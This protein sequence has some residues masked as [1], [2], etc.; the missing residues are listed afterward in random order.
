MDYREQERTLELERLER[1]RVRTNES[2][3]DRD[4]YSKQSVYRQNKMSQYDN[5]RFRR[6]QQHKKQAA[7]SEKKQNE[8]RREKQNE[9]AAEKKLKKQ[10]T[11]WWW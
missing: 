11:K 7:K 3:N 2:K 6:R 5:E 4:D 9:K 8:T 10:K 1:E